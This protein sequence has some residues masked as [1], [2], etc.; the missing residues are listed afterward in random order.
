MLPENDR[1]I[2]RALVLNDPEIDVLVDAT[3]KGIPSLR[4]PLHLSQIGRQGWNVLAGDCPLPLAVIRADIMAS[5]SAWMMAFARMHELSLAPHGKTTMAP[6]LFKRQLADGAWAITVAT[7]QQLQVC[8]RAGIR[9]IVLANQPIGRSIDTCFEALSQC[10]DLELYVLA[11]STAG[12]E[13]L[14]ARAARASRDDPGLRVL[15][16]VGARGART[17]CRD[18]ESAVSLAQAIVAAPGLQLAGVEAFEGIL[19]DAAQAAD[20]IGRLVET[21]RAI[22]ALGLFG[23][24]I[25]LSAGG[26]TF[27]DLVALG[28]EGLSLSRPLRRVL[29]SGC[30]LTHDDLSYSHALERIARERR[31]SL[32]EGSLRPALQVWSYVQSRPDADKVLLTMGK[33][34]VGYDS[35]LP[36]PVAWFRPGLMREPAA[37]V[38]G[39]SI[40]AL[41]DQHA[42]MSVP[43]DSPLSVGDM[44]AVGIAHPCTTFERWQVIMLVDERL[45]IID[46][47][48]TYF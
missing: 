41:N 21:A 1:T 29:R 16:E 28:F 22:D 35:G 3:T 36:Q 38:A 20:L 27:F 44:I 8:V 42:H 5:N 13:S 34:D 11:D 47:V 40:T 46:A 9:R 10:R 26:S 4:V 2:S 37:T 15:V 19:P 32:P 45:D 43:A 33:R 14:A 23:R 24:E 18:L 30:Y 17:G 25:L 39:C 31:L 48:R 7:G 6:A 12:V